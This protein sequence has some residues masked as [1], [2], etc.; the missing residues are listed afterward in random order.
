MLP[1]KEISIE[2]GKKIATIQAEFNTLFPFLKLEF[3]SRAPA[4]EDSHKKIIR[5]NLS[6]LGECRSRHISG[7]IVISPEMTVYELEKAFDQSFGLWVQVFRRSGRVWI[8]TS[9]TNSWTLQKQNEEG[10][11]LSRHFSSDN[12]IN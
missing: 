10:E 8:E 2:D 1:Q 9:V 6:T 11:E 4:G 7:A 5:S 3:F 12:R